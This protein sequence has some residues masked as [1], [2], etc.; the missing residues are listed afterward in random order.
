MIKKIIRYLYY[1][2]C[3][4]DI[5]SMTR[6]QLELFDKPQDLDSLAANVRELYF[7]DAQRLLEDASLKQ[8]LDET[9]DD[10]K[11][12]MHLVT[13]DK[14]I[15][16]DRFSINGISLIKEKIEL[17]AS[18]VPQDPETFDKHAIT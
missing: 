13:E 10:I 11:E 16:F 14:F 9:I 2:F 4:P 1:R 6:R 18:K 5:V 15:I 7:H 3:D 12:N 17:Y 8:I